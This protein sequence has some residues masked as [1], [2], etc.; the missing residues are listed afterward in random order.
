MYLKNINNKLSQFILIVILFI[1][2]CSTIKLVGD[3]DEKIDEGITGLQKTT[4]AH[5]LSIE[6]SNTDYSSTKEYYEKAK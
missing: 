5:L 3:Y 4:E 1:S 2:G 6:E